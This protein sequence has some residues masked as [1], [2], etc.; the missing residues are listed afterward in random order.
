MRSLILI[1]HSDLLARGV[2]ELVQQMAPDARVVPVGGTDDGGLGTSFD[3]A[4]SAAND[5]DGAVI[6]YDLGSA[7]IVAE[8][9]ADMA[10]DVEVR[11]DDIVEGA[12]T[13]ALELSREARGVETG[14]AVVAEAS[15]S[16]AAGESVD[17]VLPIDLHARPAA[18]LARYCTELGG[19][20]FIDGVDAS[21]FV[22]IGIADLRANTKVTVT[23]D[24]ASEVAGWLARLED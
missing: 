23:G 11:D 6:L 22:A 1:S 16:A 3:R 18:Q 4:L 9:V 13:V 17:V 7:R 12:I 2:A 19:T 20:T 5:A 8:M 21:D 10:D 15:E 24:H 14:N